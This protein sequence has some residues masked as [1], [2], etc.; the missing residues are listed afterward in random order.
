MPPIAAEA[1]PDGV[2]PE[3]AAF[4][5]TCGGLEIRVLSDLAVLRRR[6]DVDLDLMMQRVRDRAEKNM[7]H[8]G[9]LTAAAADLTARDPRVL[10]TVTEAAAAADARIADALDLARSASSANAQ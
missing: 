9:R 1:A 6:V 8:A 10:R 7:G 2:S 3:E 4:G 5:A